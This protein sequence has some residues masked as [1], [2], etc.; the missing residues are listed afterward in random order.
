MEMQMKMWECIMSWKSTA[1]WLYRTLGAPCVGNL[2][3]KLGYAACSFLALVLPA[4]K[5]GTELGHLTTLESHIVF[6]SFNHFEDIT[7]AFSWFLPSTVLERSGEGMLGEGRGVGFNIFLFLI[8][9]IREKYTPY[10]LSPNFAT[11]ETQDWHGERRRSWLQWH[12]RTHQVTVILEDDAV[13]HVSRADL[14]RLLKG[15]W[16]P[17]SGCHRLWP[18]SGQG[19]VA[20]PKPQARPRSGWVLWCEP[21]YGVLWMLTPT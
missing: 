16:F 14:R 19:W 13:T 12:H 10:F 11:L 1:W 15:W 21:H 17:Q 6:F 3:C 2:L 5:L 4:L 18:Q 9:K 20:L 7:Q 8:Y